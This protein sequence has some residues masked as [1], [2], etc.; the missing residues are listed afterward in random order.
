MTNQL[1]FFE[2]KRNR[3]ITV[4]VISLGVLLLLLPASIGFGSG[5]TIIMQEAFGQ[6]NLPLLEEEETGE[7]NGGGLV[8]EDEEEVQE[9][10][11]TTTTAPITSPAPTTTTNEFIQDPSTYML[12]EVNRDALRGLIGSTLPTYGVAPTTASDDDDDDDSDG[13]IATGRFRLFA[14]ETIVRRFITEMNVAAIDRS[15]FHNITIEQDA[16]HRF[17]ARQG[18]GTTAAPT[19]SSDIVGRIYLDGSATPII[20]NVPMTLIIRN[21]SLAIENIDIDE[22]R[23]TDPV[24]RDILSIID[25]QTIYGIVTG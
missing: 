17:P 9:G 5:R 23:I 18:N 2:D 12:N 19:A 7:E 25:G 22:T 8:V 15:S 13:H 1:P 14:N 11:S 16:P 20:Y 3:A 6:F 24:Q 10:D 21:Q 4:A